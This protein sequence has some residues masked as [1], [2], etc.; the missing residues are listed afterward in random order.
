[1]TELTSNFLLSLFESDDIVIYTVK[2]EDF[3]ETSKLL[4]IEARDRNNKE[5]LTYRSTLFTVPEKVNEVVKQWKMNKGAI[6]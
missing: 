3:G 4:V 6:A 5:F 1:M 2:L